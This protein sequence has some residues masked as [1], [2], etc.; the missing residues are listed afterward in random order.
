MQVKP[1]SG[2]DGYMVSSCGKVFNKDGHKM[3]LNNNGTGYFQVK[4][5]AQ[6]TRYNRYI[7]RIVWEAFM[8]NIPDKMEINHKDHNKN[9]NNLDNLEVV[10]RSTNMKRAVRH[11]GKFGFLN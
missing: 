5:Y 3:A 10:D 7:H 4:M 2:F 11:Y 1:V 9:N 8:G 6:G